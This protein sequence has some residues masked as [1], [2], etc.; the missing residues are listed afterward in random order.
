MVFGA[1][2]TTAHSKAVPTKMAINAEGTR[3]ESLGNHRE[4]TKASTWSGTTGQHCAVETLFQKNCVKRIPELSEFFFSCQAEYVQRF[5]KI[6]NVKPSTRGEHTKRCGKAMVSSLKTDRHVWSV[7]VCLLEGTSNISQLWK[8]PY[9]ISQ[10][11]YSSFTAINWGGV[12][13]YCFPLHPVILSSILMSS[14]VLHPKYEPPT[15]LT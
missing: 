11:I 10:A 13:L 2:L 12:W 5:Q 6:I 15:S 8:T 1:R 9:G 3:V 7:F 14:F 4:T